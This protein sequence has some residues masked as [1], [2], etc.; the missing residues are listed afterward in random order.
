[1]SLE[2]FDV[3]NMK[4]LEKCTLCPRKCG[5]NRLYGE[6]GYCSAGEQVEI[7]R[8]M[9]HNWEE[10]CISSGKGSGTVFFTHC[11]LSCV[12]CQNS[13]ISQEGYGKIVS[14]ERLSEIYLELQKKGAANINLV[15]PTHYIPQ[16]IESIKTARKKGL[17]IPIV[18]NSN[19]YE[20]LESLKLLEGFIDVY[21]P[22]IKYYYDNT[23]L[24]YSNAPDYFN[25]AS[26]AVLEMYRQVGSPEFNGEI[27]KKGLIIRHLLLP[28]HLSESKKIIDWI[29]ANLPKSIFVSFMSQYVPVYKASH[30]PEINRK[31]SPKSYEWLIDYYISKG[32]EN[33]FMQDYTSAQSIYTPDFNLDG[34]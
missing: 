15:S 14:I 10:P 24:K 30:Y 19:G 34:V 13:P 27:I 31:V 1:M 29:A 23:A 5:V 28:G 12:F 11:S 26:Q 21:L 9:L 33:G 25:T 32:M 17:V 20:S 7:A 16:I 6:R 18:Y 22:D 3:E 8:A 4:I 2:V